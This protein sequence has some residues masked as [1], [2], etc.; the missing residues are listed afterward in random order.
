VEE[1]MCR[2]AVSNFWS[3]NYFILHNIQLAYVENL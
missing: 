3:A 1:K 2:E